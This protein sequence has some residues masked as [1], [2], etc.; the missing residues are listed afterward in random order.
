[1]PPFCPNV[2][3]NV[4]D[5]RKPF[6]SEGIVFFVDTNVWFWYTTVIGY[7]DGK[8]YQIDDYPSFIS[9]VLGTGKLIASAI[10]L[11]ELSFVIEDV[12]F[13]IFRED[14]RLQRRP[15]I[16]KKEYRHKFPEKRK[17]IV[18]EIKSSWDSVKVVAEIT[19]TN[20]DSKKDIESILDS[21]T[22]SQVD[23]YD[24]AILENM[25]R[26][27]TSC[28]LSDDCDFVTV[29]GITIYT[30]NPSVIEKARSLQRLMPSPGA[31]Q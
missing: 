1:M 14:C 17:E 15:Q 10:N 12:H 8:A 23:A 7:A 5:I 6:K 21:V 22:N 2:R 13:D 24:L 9:S 11:I 4:V 31:G 16:T 18:Q 30:A 27:R 19:D 26:A 28:I 25:K 29:P 20:L 3:A